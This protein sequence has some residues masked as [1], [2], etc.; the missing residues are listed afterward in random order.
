LVK[1]ER[2]EGRK[3][4]GKGTKEGREVERDFRV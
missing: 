1:E 4:R 2:N 3:E